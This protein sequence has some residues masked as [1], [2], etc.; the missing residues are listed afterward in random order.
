MV[1]PLIGVAENQTLGTPGFGRALQGY[2]PPQLY[3]RY[4]TDCMELDD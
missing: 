4:R 2:H 1:D 3:V